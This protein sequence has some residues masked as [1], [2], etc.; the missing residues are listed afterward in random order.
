MPVMETSV[1]AVFGSVAAFAFTRWTARFVEWL[2]PYPIAVSIQPD[3]RVLAFAIVLGVGTSAL[4]GLLPAI[5]SARVDL[6][7]LLRAAAVGAR[8]D[9]GRTRAVDGDDPDFR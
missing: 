3:V 1:I 2:M 6:L 9:R 5:R 8:L 4:F 7:S